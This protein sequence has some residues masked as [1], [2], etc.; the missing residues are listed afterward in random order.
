MELIKDVSGEVAFD[1]QGPEVQPLLH[2]DNEDIKEASVKLTCRH[3]SAFPD[4][5]IIGQRHQIRIVPITRISYEWR[6]RMHHFY[7]Y[8]FENKAYVPRYPQ[9]CCWGCQIL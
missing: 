1:E 6:S 3:A 7:V 4:Q 2:V 9:S 8:G 5:R